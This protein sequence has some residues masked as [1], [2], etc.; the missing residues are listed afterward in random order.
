MFSAKL[1][2]NGVPV[3]EVY[4]HRG[5]MLDP[6]SLTFVYDY[7]V[8]EPKQGKVINGKMPHSYYDGLDVLVAN[9][10]NEANAERKKED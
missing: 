9:I 1:K 6:D 4:G 10:L 8:W 7:S 2:M 5:D 3:M